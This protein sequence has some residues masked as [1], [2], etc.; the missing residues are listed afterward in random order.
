M[1]ESADLVFPAGGNGYH[2]IAI[3]QLLGNGDAGVQRTG[4][5]AHK[6]RDNNRKDDYCQEGTGKYRND[7]VARYRVKCIPAVSEF[8]VT[9]DCAFRPQNLPLIN[10][11][12]RYIFGLLLG[13]DRLHILIIENREY[14]FGIAGD[15]FHQTVKADV[16]VVQQ[17]T[18]ADLDHEVG[19]SV[20]LG[21][22]G[23][24]DVLAVVEGHENAK[25]SHQQDH[26]HNGY[27]EKFLPYG[28]YPEK[29]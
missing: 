14:H 16:I 5:T 3:G 21:L 29:M 26:E 10:E 15:L 19:N 24:I 1:H 2:E 18:R 12:V 13:G 6:E 4:D 20:A 11:Q 22:H 9:K 27:I 25:A 23:G 7:I 17:I 8:Q 28:V